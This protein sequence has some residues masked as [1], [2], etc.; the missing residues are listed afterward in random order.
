[1][2]RLTLS[3]LAIAVMVGGIALLF[4]A[5]RSSSTEGNTNAA[6]EQ[7]ANKV[8]QASAGSNNIADAKGLPKSGQPKVGINPYAGALKEPGKSK[9]SWDAGFMKTQQQAAAGDAIEFELT[10][11]RTAK[12]VVKITQYRSGELSY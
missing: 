10:E 9:R 2:K 7:I 5:G 11:G 6:V 12:G 1:M 4:W 8:S 3:V